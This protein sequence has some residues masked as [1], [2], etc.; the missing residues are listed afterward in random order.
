MPFIPERPEGA[1]FRTLIV[2][3]DGTGDSVDKDMTNVAHLKT[4]LFGNH[5]SHDNQMVLYLRGI[6]SPMDGY[7]PQFDDEKAHPWKSMAYRTW[8]QAFASS[9]PGYVTEPYRWLSKNYKDGDKICIFGFSRGAYT[10]RVLAGLINAFGL[11]PKDGVAA[12]QAAYSLYDD[13]VDLPERSEARKP[14]LLDLLAKFDEFKVR[15][16]CRDVLIEFLGCWD[17]VNSVGY[18][19]AIKLGFTRTNNIVRTFRH[20]VALDEHRVKFKQSNW[21]SPPKEVMVPADGLTNKKKLSVVTNVEEVWFAGCHCD[22]G[23]GSVPNGRRPNLAHIPLRWMIREC[24]KA[25]TGIMFDEHALRVL[26]IE[27]ASIYP[28]VK[29]RPQLSSFS[30]GSAT[31]TVVQPQTWG[32]YLKSWIPFTSSPDEATDLKVLDKTEEEM[33]AMDALAPAYDQLTL[34]PGKW[35]A[36]EQ[37]PMT[38]ERK[39][40]DNVFHEVRERHLG[41]GRTI[42]PPEDQH[43][44][45]IKVHRTVRLRMESKF[46]S[47]PEK[48]KK[49]VPLARIGYAEKYDDKILFDQA[50]VSSVEWVA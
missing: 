10:A 13:F 15:E 5:A 6:G 7:D 20:A 11:L 12:S 2:L 31:I 26:G 49:Y 46:E 32:A 29:S 4:M 16:K 37:I 25:N 41:H 21:S 22:I 1:S 19:R 33:D 3:L 8:E 40:K 36:M 17:T 45:K 48:G 14:K 35:T 39:G 28:V 9:F 44:E 43:G 42:P 23:G 47:G 38:K 24:F 30:S 18:V 27:P 50:A 34:K